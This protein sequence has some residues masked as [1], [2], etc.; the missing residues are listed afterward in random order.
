MAFNPA[1]EK[2]S[3]S[4]PAAMHAHI[5]ALGA[6]GMQDVTIEPLAKPVT[7]LGKCPP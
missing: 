1:G 4:V 2:T 3:A 6:I 5:A 7:G